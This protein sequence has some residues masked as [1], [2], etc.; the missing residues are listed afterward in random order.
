MPGYMYILECSDGLYYTGSTKDLVR[1]LIQHMTGINGANFTRKRLPVKLAYF[2]IFP[3]VQQ[4]YYREK[5]VQ[6]WSR[7]KKEALIYR[8]FEM[9]H[10]LA[11]CQNETHFKNYLRE[12]GE[13]PF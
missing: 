8:Q 6:G 4:A 9:L 7:A 13:M 10:T 1:R 11:E 3:T 2:E 5:Q 12:E